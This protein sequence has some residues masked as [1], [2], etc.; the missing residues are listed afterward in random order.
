MGNTRVENFS[1]LDKV[2]TPSAEDEVFKQND[3]SNPIWEYFLEHIHGGTAKCKKCDRILRIKGGST[4]S[5]RNHMK[6]KHKLQVRLSAAYNN[7][8]LPL[9]NR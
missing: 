8:H 5:M 7:S 6:L 9:I 2:W 1:G 3:S 4:G